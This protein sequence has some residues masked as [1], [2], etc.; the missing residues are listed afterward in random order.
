MGRDDVEHMAG[1]WVERIFRWIEY[2]V[3]QDYSANGGQFYS[4]AVGEEGIGRIMPSVRLGEMHTH[5]RAR[6]YFI[7]A[8]ISDTNRQ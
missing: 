8:V 4:V 6:E 5:E 3:C 7:Q 2:W 1:K